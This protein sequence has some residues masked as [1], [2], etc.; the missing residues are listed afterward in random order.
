M[1]RL[2]EQALGIRVKGHSMSNRPVVNT[3]ASQIWMKFCCVEFLQYV[4]KREN[5]KFEQNRTLGL[6]DAALQKQLKV[7][8]LAPTVRM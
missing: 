6:E 1:V 4:A 2:C 8:K 3:L 7:A 5:T